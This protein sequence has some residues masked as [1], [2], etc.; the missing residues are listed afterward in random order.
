MYVLTVLWS[1]IQDWWRIADNC[2]RRDD[3]Y[4]LWVCP[5]AVSFVVAAIFAF[6]S[7][8]HVAC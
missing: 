8:M 1:S 6:D 7:C 5:K 3:W 4:G 2:I